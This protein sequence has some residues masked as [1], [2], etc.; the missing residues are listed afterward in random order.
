[1]IPNNLKVFFYLKPI[2]MRKS[3]KGL[4]IIVVD[5]L[6]MDTMSGWIFLF[7]NRFKDKIKA[8]NWDKNGLCYM[9]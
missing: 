8:L 5:W 1:M 9:F 6:G 4:S 3:I 2:D 7:Y